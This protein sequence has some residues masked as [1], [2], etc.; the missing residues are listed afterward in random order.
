MK[1]PPPLTRVGGVHLVGL[2]SSVKNKG[3]VVISAVN[4]LMA[5]Y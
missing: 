3:G 5:A 1:I 4:L 2:R